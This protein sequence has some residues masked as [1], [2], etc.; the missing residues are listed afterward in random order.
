MDALDIS[1]FAHSSLKISPINQLFVCF[2]DESALLC[3]S[4]C[5][6]LPYLLLKDNFVDYDVFV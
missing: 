4:H 3:S 1:E 2:C 5:S 6:S